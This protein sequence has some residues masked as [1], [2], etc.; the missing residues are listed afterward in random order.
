MANY[1]YQHYLPSGHQKL[2]SCDDDS[3]GFVC[4]YDKRNNVVYSV[5]QNPKN[6]GG[7][8]HLYS[9]PSSLISSEE[10]KIY[11]EQKYFSHDGQFVGVIQKLINNSEITDDDVYQITKY[12]ANIN[13]RHPA[14]LEDNEKDV[15]QIALNTMLGNDSNLIDFLTSEGVEFIP[16]DNED[17]VKIS[18][19]REML[20]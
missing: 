20:K 10:Q 19:L 8:K 6:H 13:N 12:I 11:L 9:Y 5:M 7:K 18:N 14:I 3:R 4:K 17:F 16:E 1:K 2:F 15:T